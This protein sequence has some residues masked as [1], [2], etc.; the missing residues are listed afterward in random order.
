M[1][2][3]VLQEAVLSKKAQEWNT[4][5]CTLVGGQAHRYEVVICQGANP[6]DLPSISKSKLCLQCSASSPPLM[7][8]HA[9]HAESPPP[10]LQANEPVFYK[11]P[12]FLRLVAFL[13]SF[14]AFGL[15]IFH[16]ACRQSHSFGLGEREA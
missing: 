14:L 12:S 6:S 15:T 8:T 4:G 2:W 5:L 16:G 13:V 1:V 3:D 7:I 10:H 11:P 9:L